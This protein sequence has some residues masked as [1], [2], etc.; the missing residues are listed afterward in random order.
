VLEGG[1]CLRVTLL[2]QKG[3]TEVVIGFRGCE[4]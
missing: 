2:E 1:N 4:P 3:T